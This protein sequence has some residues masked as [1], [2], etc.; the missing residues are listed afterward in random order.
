MGREEVNKSRERG[1][2]KDL[3]EVTQVSL[4]MQLGIPLL[5]ISIGKCN[6]VVRI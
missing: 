3:Q 5:F 1:P 4:E 6:I 2:H